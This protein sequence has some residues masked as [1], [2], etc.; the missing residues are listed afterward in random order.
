MGATGNGTVIP[1]TFFGGASDK[2]KQ[3]EAEFVKRAMAFR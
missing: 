3:F 1:T 2:G